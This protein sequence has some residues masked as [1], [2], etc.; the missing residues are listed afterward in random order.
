LTR[1]GR[2]IR[3]WGS[4]DP[5]PSLRRSPK[6]V[7]RPLPA[8]DLY[9]DTTAVSPAQLT[10]DGSTTAHHLSEMGWSMTEL[11]VKAAYR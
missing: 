3:A 1:Y 11:P 8:A 5:H 6:H 9:R 2:F 7:V 4:H 10:R